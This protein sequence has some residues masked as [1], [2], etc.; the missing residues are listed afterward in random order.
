MSI[1]TF[2]ST[3]LNTTQFSSIFQFMLNSKLFSSEEKVERNEDFCLF[4]AV[5][6]S[7]LSVQRKDTA[8]MTVLGRGD[9][10]AGPDIF[11]K[12]IS[13]ILRLRIELDQGQGSG[14]RVKGVLWSGLEFKVRSRTMKDRSRRSVYTFVS[15]SACLLQPETQNAH[16]TS[17]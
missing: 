4:A 13:L 6:E 1:L 14:V 11:E 10:L 7:F 9:I 16:C 5:V 3:N 15:L 12:H 8:V 17:Q 2:V